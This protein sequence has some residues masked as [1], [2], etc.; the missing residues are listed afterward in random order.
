MSKPSSSLVTAA[1]REPTTVIDTTVTTVTSV[2]PVAS[3]LKTV[4]DFENAMQ[5]GLVTSSYFQGSAVSSASMI[6]DQYIRSGF[7]MEHAALTNLGV[8]HA[9]SGTMAISPVSTV[10]KVDYDAPVILHFV[11]AVDTSITKTVTQ[12]A[13]GTSF[14]AVKGNGNS[15][16]TNNDNSIATKNANG[17]TPV[18]DYNAEVLTSTITK[19]ATASTTNANYVDGTVDYFAYSPDLDGKSFN[20]ITITALAL[21]GHKVGQVSVR[22]TTNITAPIACCPELG[23]SI[24]SPLTAH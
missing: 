10:G 6:T 23:S 2:T 3:A 22:E 7:V 19:T 12:I 9:A 11:K 17:A 16:A 14:G 4:L 20:T 13:T 1:V 5:L 8:G 18:N 21:D 24:V 15:I